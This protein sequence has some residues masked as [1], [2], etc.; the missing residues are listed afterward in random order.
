MIGREGAHLGIQRVVLRALGGQQDV[1]E[2]VLFLHHD[3]PV[4]VSTLRLSHAEAE[5]LVKGAALLQTPFPRGRSRRSPRTLHSGRTAGRY[6]L[7]QRGVTWRSWSRCQ[8]RHG[9]LEKLDR[10]ERKRH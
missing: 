6:G 4:A 3:V 2:A 8:A 5:T 1:G 7:H 10:C 9:W